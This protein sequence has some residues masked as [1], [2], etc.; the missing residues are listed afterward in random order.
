MGR[1]K[2]LYLLRGL[3][4]SGKSTLAKTLA[5]VHIE[6]DM[7]FVDAEGIYKFDPQDWGHAN[8]WCEN[9]VMEAMEASIKDDSGKLD[10]IIVS[11]PFIKEI[12]LVPYYKMAKKYGYHV[13]SVIVENRH[14]LRDDS[15][16]PDYR[17][18]KMLDQF[19]I[20]LI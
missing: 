3:P 18:Q 11:N 5:G 15:N 10:T 4:D 19:E 14:T 20:K 16:V 2:L 6:S 17:T 9:N 1:L 8:R 7:F 12:E 13:F